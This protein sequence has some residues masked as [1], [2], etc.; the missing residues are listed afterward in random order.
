MSIEIRENQK[1]LCRNGEIITLQKSEEHPNYF[2]H[3]D[4]GYY[5]DNEKFGC[6]ICG[7]A[8]QSGEFTHGYD[9]VDMH[10]D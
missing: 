9:I 8:S 3:R 4:S 10:F 5:Y 1:Y 2:I 7:R 6:F